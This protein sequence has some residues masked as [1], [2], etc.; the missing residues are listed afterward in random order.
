[1]LTRVCVQM[2]T[3]ILFKNGQKVK[4]VIGANPQALQ[5]REQ[6]ALYVFAS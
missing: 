4:E 1:M 6:S 3:F 2:P 5:V